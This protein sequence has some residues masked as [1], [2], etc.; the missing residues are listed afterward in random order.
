MSTLCDYQ[1]PA[2]EK[3]MFLPYQYKILDE[4]NRDIFGMLYQHIKP[5]QTV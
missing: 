2:L 4:T 1:I 5:I 3:L